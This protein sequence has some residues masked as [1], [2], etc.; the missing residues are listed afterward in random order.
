MANVV[1]ILK[2]GEILKIEHFLIGEQA[3]GK[4]KFQDG[5]NF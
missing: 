1:K 2:V 5:K 3:I 4:E